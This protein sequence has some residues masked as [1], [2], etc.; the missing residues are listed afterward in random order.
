MTEWVEL[1]RGEQKLRLYVTHLLGQEYPD[2]KPEWITRVWDRQESTCW[3]DTC[4]IPA[5]IFVE[6]DLDGTSRSKE[7]HDIDPQAVEEW[8]N[9]NVS[10]AVFPDLRV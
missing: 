3:N 4:I 7:F 5:A 9:D 2:L 10:T 1:S 6:F 8:Y